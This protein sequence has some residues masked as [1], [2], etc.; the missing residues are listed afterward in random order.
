VLEYYQK[1]DTSQLSD[2]ALAQRSK[3]LTLMGQIASLR[4]DLDRASDLYEQA[5]AGTA[6]AVRRDPGNPQ[7]L[8]E[9]AQNVFYLGDI[10]RQRGDLK[11]VEAA[12]REYQRLARQMVALDPDNMKWRMEEQDA[13][14]NL[15][16]ALQSQRRFVEAGDQFEQALQS[17]SALATADPHNR[18]YQ[19]S[20]TEA[21]AWLA[22]ARL[23][24]GRL[25]PAIEARERQ[26]DIL[27]RL[28]SQAAD[29]AFRQ[30]LIPAEQALGRLFDARGEVAAAEEHLTASTIMADQLVPLE[31]SNSKWLQFAAT[32]HL[33]L[34][35]HFLVAGRT[36]QAAVETRKACQVT[37]RLL[38]RDSTVVDWRSDQR[39]CLSLQSQLALADGQSAR[40]ISFARQALAI[41][42]GTPRGDQVDRRYAI[43]KAERLLGDVYLASGDKQAAADSWRRAFASLP[44]GI[45]ERPWELSE[46]A[47]ILARLGRTAEAAQL[48]ARL[49]AMGIKRSDLL[50]VA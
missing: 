48:S 5:Y 7:R 18:D 14:A 8:Y 25:G 22:D 4:G 47:Q 2:A 20:L 16:I 39:S 6:E 42:T 43:A 37:S 45:A 41:A 10:A 44:A 38:A 19:M 13:D 23:A 3:A 40:A 9:H 15:G 30:K 28:N 17:I 1:Q 26:I 33:S 49:A 21:L 35:K 11:G 24:A 12:A 29:V 27:K 36:A 34:A 50:K 32:A 46:R 31:P